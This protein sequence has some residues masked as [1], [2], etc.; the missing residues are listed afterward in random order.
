MV[1]S[2]KLTKPPEVV[3]FDAAKAV[4][5][6]VP[7]NVATTCTETYFDSLFKESKTRIC[8]LG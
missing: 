2:V 3:T 6:Y 5:W 7:S 4:L 8:G 1:K